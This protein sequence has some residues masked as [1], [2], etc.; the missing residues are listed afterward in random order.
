M[1]L[2]LI[3]TL[4]LSFLVIFA[5]CTTYGHNNATTEPS[6]TSSN[7]TTPTQASGAKAVL[8]PTQ[9]SEIFSLP[10]MVL[11]PRYLNNS[12]IGA[13]DDNYIGSYECSKC[14]ETFGTNYTLF[15]GSDGPHHIHYTLMPVDPA[16]ESRVVSLSPDVLKASIYPDDFISRPGYAYRSQINVT[17]G[18]NVTGES[19]TNRDGSGW[20]RDP[21]FSF[22][23]NVTVD[24]NDTPDA[25]D[26]ITVTKMCSFHSQTRG[27]QP[28]PG[29][30]SG[31]ESDIELP[32]GESKSFVIQARNYCGGLRELYFDIPSRINKENW[33]FPLESN[34]EQNLPIPAGLTFSFDPP[35]MTGINYRLSNTTLIIQTDPYLPPGNYSFP[36]ILCYRNL[37]LDNKSS[38]H[39]PFSDRPYCGTATSFTVDIV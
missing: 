12:T 16:D 39:F 8:I 3:S 22:R 25:D 13:F 14:S 34:P 26:H 11:P 29:I 6:F 21:Y 32:A 20:S 18:P 5:G 36:L 24:G 2:F 10:P 17:L 4:F 37:D 33:S 1:K 27:M 30:E 28:I 19:H 23:L 7:A 35:V 15:A 38:M 9:S 31:L